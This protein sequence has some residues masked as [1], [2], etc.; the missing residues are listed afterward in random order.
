MVV[1]LSRERSSISRESVSLC[2]Q[3]VTEDRTRFYGAEIG[4]LLPFN[5]PATEHS[6]NNGVLSLARVT[7]KNA[8]SISCVVACVG[9]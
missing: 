7:G 4:Q 8:A 9:S 1:N 6:P 2:N 3:F 5:N